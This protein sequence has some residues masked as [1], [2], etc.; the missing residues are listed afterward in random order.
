MNLAWRSDRRQGRT[1]WRAGQPPRAYEAHAAGEVWDAYW[2]PERNVR[3]LIDGCY[4]T[5]AAA[6]ARCQER[7]TQAAR[8]LGEEA[9]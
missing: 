7:E 5:A 2:L 4:P 8:S 3:V 1:V 9:A 6:R